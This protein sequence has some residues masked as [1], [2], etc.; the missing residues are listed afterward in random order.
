MFE[1]S[2]EYM[3][4]IT[5]DALDRDVIISAKVVIKEVNGKLKAYCE[6]TKTYLQFPRAIRRAGKRFEADVIKA[7]TPGKIFYRAYRGSICEV[8]NGVVGDPIA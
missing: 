7:S 1:R 3:A 2:E 5:M 8:I 6:D 4:N